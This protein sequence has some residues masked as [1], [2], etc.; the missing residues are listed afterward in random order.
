MASAVLLLV[1]SQPHVKAPAEC[2]I[3]ISEKP[4]DG[5]LSMQEP[6]TEKKKLAKP[7]VISN[8]PQVAIETKSVEP[9][10]PV[11]TIEERGDAMLF[12]AEALGGM[13]FDH[14]ITMP[15]D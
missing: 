13:P 4:M 14:A 5:F 1:L 11:Q 10:E 3:V 7:M 8:T 2:E 9:V 12:E 15:F 6:V